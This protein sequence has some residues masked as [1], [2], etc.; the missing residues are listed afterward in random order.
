MTGGVYNLCLIIVKTLKK[1]NLLYVTLPKYY[2]IISLQ[3]ICPTQDLPTTLSTFNS[4]LFRLQLQILR[5]FFLH[6]FKKL[7]FEGKGYYSFRSQRA[8][9]APKFGYAHKLYLYLFDTSVLF[10]SKTKV[11]FFGVSRGRV[12]SYSLGFFFLRPRNLYTG[13]GVRFSRSIRYKKLGKVST[14]R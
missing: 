7:R 12:L 14:Y 5:S 4:F 1:K 11:L 9:V 6:F 3:A 13:R 8:V 10:L 2:F